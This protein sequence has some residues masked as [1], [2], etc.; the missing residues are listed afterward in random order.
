MLIIL[1]ITSFII[2]FGASFI[3]YYNEKQNYLAWKSASA[4]Y[5][6]D[7]AIKAGYSRL[8]E[9]GFNFGMPA[10]GAAVA[11]CFLIGFECVTVVPA[12]HIGVQVTFG[13]VNQ[14]TLPEGMHLVNPMSRIREIEV[15]MV[16]T[17]LVNGSAG[18]K[19]LQQVH[20]DI[21]LNYRLDGSKAAHIYKEFGLDLND[22][23][24]LPALSESFKAVTAHYT[25][26]E[27]ITKRDEVSAR[28]REEI[29]SKLA[30]Y[31]ITVNDVN[32]MNFSFS[33]EYQKA[34]EAKVTATQAKLKAEQDLER[35]KIEAQQSIAR[36]EGEA[37]AI[38][39]QSQAIQTNGGA[40]YVQL[41]AIEKWDGNLPNVMSG[42]NTPF[43]NIK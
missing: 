10:M 31:N 20:T 35:I 12:G 2:A 21:A 23:V 37:K 28:T 29:A 40:N 32:L 15:R 38:A 3:K 19:D 14:A 4:R 27:L 6:E 42:N 9:P 41:K 33:P 1:I 34:I 39:I 17:K 11:S 25:S 26:E 13:E 22:R 24:I 43:I 7:A 8:Q 18:T 36:A 16:S 5:G 30:K